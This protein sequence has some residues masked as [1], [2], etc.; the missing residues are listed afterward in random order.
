MAPTH[1]NLQEL[2]TALPSERRSSTSTHGPSRADCRIK[3][4]PEAAREARAWARSWL[5]ETCAARDDLL[6]VL[7]ELVANAA[8]H[9][10]GGQATLVLLH[11]N[12]GVSGTLVHRSPPLTHQFDIPT[13]SAEEFVQ[14]SALNEEA[15]DDLIGGLGESGRGLFVVNALCAQPARV[16]REAGCTVTRWRLEG[17]TCC[18]RSPHLEARS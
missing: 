11:T 6:T 18:V 4:S 3:A 7:T 1:E 12:E 9:G 5:P 16:T 2:G 10:G 17:C 13:A 8:E 15:D 14:L